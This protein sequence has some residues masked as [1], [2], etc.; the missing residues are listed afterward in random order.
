MSLLSFSRLPSSSDVKMDLEDRMMKKKRVQKL[1]RVNTP[2]TI[3]E[4]LED[5]TTS[6][7]MSPPQDIQHLIE[8]DI[9]YRSY[10]DYHDYE[11]DEDEASEDKEE[12]KL[13]SSQEKPDIFEKGKGSLQL[14]AKKARVFIST[15]R[16]DSPDRLDRKLTLRMKLTSTEPEEV[17]KDKIL[18]TS[19]SITNTETLDNSHDS[20][21][22]SFSFSENVTTHARKSPSPTPSASKTFQRK[23]SKIITPKISVLLHPKVNPLEKYKMKKLDTVDSSQSMTES[24]QAH[25]V[26]RTRSESDLRT[27]S[28]TKRGARPWK[29][30]PFR[31]IPSEIDSGSSKTNIGSK[32]ESAKRKFVPKKF[33]PIRK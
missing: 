8:D 16:E 6:E 15:N 18:K 27:L 1:A 22:H 10:Q 33:E 31:K 5:S 17:E 7:S 24:T 11:S 20:K 19:T 12:I 2:D 13:S 32:Q 26:P 29:S 14:S 28:Q 23:S 4:E 30:V 25:F 3:K 9:N 21:K